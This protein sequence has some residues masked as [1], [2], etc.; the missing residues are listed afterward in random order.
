MFNDARHLR[1]QSGDHWHSFHILH[2][3]YPLVLA[4]TH[5]HVYDGVANSPLKSPF[6][7]IEFSED[8]SLITMF[9]FIEF[10]TSR[11]KVLGAKK[12]VIKACPDEYQPLKAPILHTFLFNQGFRVVSA[13]IGSVIRISPARFDAGLDEMEKR[14]LRKA[15]DAGLVFKEIPHDQLSETFLFI[16]ACRRFKGY[17]LSM[18]LPELKETVKEFEKS[19]VLFG[20]FQGEKLTAASISILVNE[21]ILY[22]F[23]PAH[24]SEFDSISPLVFL[25]SNIY[26]YC[27][28]RKIELLDL[29]TSAL[30]GKPN[31]GLL[32]F[33][34]RLGAHPTQ[35]FTFEKIVD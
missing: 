16:L 35:K 15:I 25:I 32:D 30:D 17:S 20:A 31:F 8:L 21:K 34:L 23:Y 4:S 18:T 19:F 33:K 3:K 22:N 7:S 6:G 11:L 9:R 26:G 5:F 2:E 13:E 28:R 10:V 27:Q 14:K 12:I 1:L 29:G 24:S